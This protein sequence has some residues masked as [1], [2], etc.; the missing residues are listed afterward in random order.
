MA[1]SCNC[2]SSDMKSIKAIRE[3]YN[4]DTSSTTIGAGIFSGGGV[5]VGAA[6]TSGTLA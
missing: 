6:K 2:G 1:R 5:G 3:Q 4:T